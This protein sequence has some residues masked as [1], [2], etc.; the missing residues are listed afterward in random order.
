VFCMYCCMMWIGSRTADDEHLCG[1]IL[2]A[3]NAVLTA[4]HC[5]DPR[6]TSGAL[7]NPD[8]NIGGIDRDAPVEKRKTVRAFQHPNWSG[9]TTAGDDIV[10]L[11]LNRRT[12]VRPVVTL[13]AKDAEGQEELTFLGYGRTSERGNFPNILQGS[14]MNI[15][16]RKTCRNRYDF[17]PDV[18]TSELCVRGETTVGF[19][20]GDDGGPIIVQPSL[21]VFRDVVV[22]I[23]SH[24][25]AGCTE[26]EG[27]SIFMNVRKYRK[28][29][30]QT[31]RSEEFRQ[32]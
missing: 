20:T 9:S 26:T 22:G 31:L 18:R 2:I 4:A 3:K 29:I 21:R 27:V 15:L 7:V 8:L 10:I 13:G 28:W 25:H 5:V 24:T 30:K 32:A 6:A 12:C 14:Q 19:C 1:G 17:R 11:K 16:T 23:A